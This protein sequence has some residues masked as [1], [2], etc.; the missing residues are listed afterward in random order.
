MEG[1]LGAR[2]RGSLMLRV[3]EVKKAGAWAPPEAD[4]V[5]LPY[6]AR[7]R[8]RRALKGERGLE[9]LLDRSEAT[10]LRDGDGLV[11]QDGRVVVVRA[12]AESL[13]EITAGDRGLLMRI[14]WHLGNRG[15]LMPLLRKRDDWLQAL[16]AFASPLLSGEV[17]FRLSPTFQPFAEHAGIPGGSYSSDRLV[18]R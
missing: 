6:D 10:L 9:F 16:A 11:L 7:N 15:L 14:A 4:V 12:A 5:V 17:G 8:R 1:R 13:L 18:C 3:A 2:S